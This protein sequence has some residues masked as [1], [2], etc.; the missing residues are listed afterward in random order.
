MFNVAL[1]WAFLL[2]VA[3]SPGGKF[4]AAVFETSALRTIPSYQVALAGVFANYW[5]S[6]LLIYILLVATRAERFLKP[7]N[8]IHLL[9]GLANGVLCF[10]AA[11]RVFATTVEGGGGAF[12]LASF[13][14]LITVP[15]LC[16]LLIATIWLIA[17]SISLRTDSTITDAQ[18]PTSPTRAMRSA[19]AAIALLPPFVFFGWMYFS[20][21]AQINKASEQRRAKV[22][23]LDTLCDDVRIDI[24]R[25]TGRAKSVLFSTITNATYPLVQDLDFV[26]LKQESWRTAR[27]V[28]PYERLMKKPNEPALVNG[29]HNIIRQ[30]VAESEA[31]YEISVKPIE[32]KADTAMGIAVVLAGVDRIISLVQRPDARWQALRV[33]VVAVSLLVVAVGSVW[34]VERRPW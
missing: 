32:S 30:D 25:R 3:A 12:V 16:V 8:G 4:L 18:A 22:A 26:E 29:V 1:G 2:S 19:A 6:T 17:R 33:R 11:M 21:A 34:A 28:A 27:G 13:G 31:E 14:A 10:F 7:S 23:R 24:R 9:F 20:N 15:A 5:V